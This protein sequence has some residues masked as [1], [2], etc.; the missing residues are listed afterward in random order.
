MKNGNATCTREELGFRSTA[1][2]LLQD[3]TGAVGELVRVYTTDG[4]NKDGWLDSWLLRRTRLHYD[5]NISE[6]EQIVSVTSTVTGAST[7]PKRPGLRLVSITPHYFRGF[8][9]LPN[10][11]DLTGG[12]VVFEGKN[13]SGKTSLA[14]AIEFLFTG[15]LSRRE[16]HGTGSTAELENCIVNQ[17]R[18][19]GMSTFVEATFV[20]HLGTPNQKHIVLKRVLTRDYGVTSTSACESKL[21]MNG[22]GLSKQDENAI[23]EKMFSLVPPLLMQHTLRSFVHSVPRQRR[24]YFER[25]LALDGLTE[26]IREAVIGDAKLPELKSPTGS[27]GLLRWTNLI[28]QL[29]DSEAKATA[30]KVKS[31]ERKHRSKALDS[32]LIDVAR[33]EFSSP[34]A[35][36]AETEAWIDQLQHDAR[37]ESFPPLAKLRPKQQPSYELPNTLAGTEQRK[38]NVES[39]W[40]EYEEAHAA[41]NAVQEGALVIAD[42]LEKMVQASLIDREKAVQLCPLC[43]HKNPITL[44]QK[45]LQEIGGWKPLVESENQAWA[46]LDTEIKDLKHDLSTLVQEASNTLPDLPDLSDYLNNEPSELSDAVSKLIAV[47]SQI[48]TDVRQTLDKSQSLTTTETDRFAT[49]ADVTDFATDCTTCIDKLKSLPRHAERYGRAL[50]ALENAIGRV[51]AS[52]EEYKKRESWLACAKSQEAILD[53]FVWEEA[54]LSSQKDLENVRTELINFRGK[55][56][57]GM[58]GMFSDGM[59]EVWSSLRGDT[60]SAFSNL[61]VPEPKGK[62][63]PV[64]LEVKATLDDRHERKEVDAIKVFSESQVNALGIAA[65]VTRSRLLGH[66]FLILDDPVQSMD[67]DHFKTFARDVLPP[68]LDE[69]RQVILLT[70]NETFA[71]DISYWHHE[72]SDYVTLR[73]RLS[74]K[75]GCLVDEGNRRFSERLRGAEKLANEGNHKEAWLPVRFAIERLYTLTKIKHGSNGFDPDSWKD[76][77]AEYMWDGGGVGTIISNINPNAGKRLKEI[78]TMTAGGSHDKGVHG[79]TD[80]IEATKFLRQLG[81]E[82]KIAD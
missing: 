49:L 72:R 54:K 52:D 79:T 53:D 38:S 5:G 42:A 11:I 39:R 9:N 16:D 40:K 23:L 43:V 67:E 22:T 70:H 36:L 27:S 19:I 18:P 68:I 51:A 59:Q 31:I 73:T 20:K 55:Y 71:R 41:I 26:L 44:T 65:F 17:F 15:S 77:T 7:L 58:R 33:L 76:Q 28:D 81:S 29:K 57:D 21:H 6:D 35:N 74:R 47:R 50:A 3:V 60:Y 14:E 12:L 78:L 69:G 64:V 56:L 1:L 66:D 2:G 32:A 46:N 10:A 80:L 45:R 62:G 25:I 61:H 63:F 34:S 8:K 48:E 37:Q 4:A 24:Q 30:N 75:D 82:I 13:S